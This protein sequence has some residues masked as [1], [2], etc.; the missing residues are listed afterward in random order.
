MR[1]GVAVIDNKDACAATMDPRVESIWP[2]AC[3]SGIPVGF[4]CRCCIVWICPHRVADDTFTL[5]GWII[6]RRH[7]VRC[8]S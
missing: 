1:V 7:N 5:L 8:L 4:S 2:E 3:G 6:F